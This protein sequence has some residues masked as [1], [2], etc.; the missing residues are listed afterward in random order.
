MTSDCH[1]HKSCL[2]MFEKLSEY[3]DNELDSMT[4]E[5]IERHAAACI[6]CKVCMETL[7]RTVDLCKNLDAPPVPETFS[8]RLRET[9]AHLTTPNRS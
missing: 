4:C 9:I 7:K 8:R 5:D 6:S 2:E 1:D 3:L